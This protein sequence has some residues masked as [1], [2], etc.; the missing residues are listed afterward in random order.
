[1][2]QKLQKNYIIL[3]L[4]LLLISLS[5][6][7]SQNLNVFDYDY[8][9][10]PVNLKINN[11]ENPKYIDIKLLSNSPSKYTKISICENNSESNNYIIS[12]FSDEK[13]TKSIQEDKIVSGNQK[14]WL[15][16]FQA[17]EKIYLNVECDILP[18][19][20]ILNISPE[21]NI[22]L[23]NSEQINYYVNKQNLEMT[24]IFDLKSVGK[25]EHMNIWADGEFEIITKLS[26][27]NN[28]IENMNNNFYSFKPANYDGNELTLKVTAKKGD[29]VNVG[30]QIYEKN[31]SKNYVTIDDIPVLSFLSENE[32]E[33]LQKLGVNTDYTNN[34]TNLKI[35]SMELDY[36]IENT[37]RFYYTEI[38][39]DTQGSITINFKRGSGK[40]YA[41]II[42]TNETTP[43]IYDFSNITD[44]S[45]DYLFYYNSFL[46]KINFYNYYYENDNHL[47]LLMVV[48][49]D[50]KN[51]KNLFRSFPF[52]IIL[53][54]TTAQRTPINISPDEYIIGNLRDASI[55]LMTEL[56]YMQIKND[57]D[58]IIIDFQSDGAYLFININNTNK[59]M[60]F[61][62]PDFT[63]IPSGK[64]SVYTITKS[65]IINTAKINKYDIYIDDNNFADFNLIIGLF[66]NVSDT[67]Y[68]TVFS[69]SVHLKK[70]ENDLDIYK[71]NSDQK[72]L[73]KTTFISNDEDYPYR[74]LYIISPENYSNLT[75]L[76][77][78]ANPQ[79]ESI[80]YQIYADYLEIKD[81]NEKISA[82]NI[83]NKNSKFSTD[84]TKLDY[85]YLNEGLN[86]KY[87][88]VS[89][90]SKANTTI[91]LM[92]SFNSIEEIITPNPSTP[93]LFIINNEK[94]ELIFN[95]DGDE[96]AINLRSFSGDAEIYWSHKTDNKFYLRGRD[97]RLLIFASEESNKLIIKNLNAVNNNTKNEIP[98]LA[99]YLEYTL[100][101]M[102][103]FD[104][105]QFGKSVNFEYINPNFPIEIYTKL[106]NYEK[107]INIFFSFYNIETENNEEVSDKITVKAS[108]VKQVTIYNVKGNPETSIGTNMIPG[109]YDPGLRAGFFRLTKDN[110]KNFEINITDLPNLYIS[111]TDNKDGKISYN[112]V[113]LEMTVIQENSLIL[114][115][116]KIYQYGSLN[117]NEINVYKLRPNLNKP[118]MRI[119]FSSTGNNIKYYI[120]KS[121]EYKNDDNI[122]IVNETSCNG[123]ELIDIYAD[124]E[125]NDYLYLHLYR[126]NN[127]SDQKENFAFKYIN[128]VQ[129]SNLKVYYIE[130]S[131]INSSQTDGNLVLEFYPVP[132]STLFN[133]TYLVKLIKDKIITL[134]ETIAV[135]SNDICYVKEFKNPNI[136][137][138][139]INLK[140]PNNQK[141]IYYVIIY[142]LVNDK[143]IKE[144]ISYK[145]LQLNNNKNESS[146]STFLIVMVIIILLVTVCV[147]MIVFL[148]VFF[149]RNK[150]L[151]YKV[152]KLSFKTDE[153]SRDL[154]GT[155]LYKNV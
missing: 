20:Y 36:I 146:S 18:C 97:D 131:K 119:E 115:T 2:K 155:A 67:V 90:V 130:D 133:V 80:Q 8:E 148:F 73:C 53:R 58:K 33:P 82:S 103:N 68:T 59:G 144:Y 109:I 117:S 92:S 6:I 107:D 137:N 98:S 19:N 106:P 147:I 121:P 63:F 44:D 52:S 14:L 37:T 43:N 116:E 3:Y 142:A 50:T 89:V 54:S 124:P 61:L 114:A 47:F 123:R 132:N 78:Y 138:E 125:K 143:S 145:V 105:I 91:E 32:N 4:I 126:E 118:N 100:K 154:G 99:F 17:N 74:C 27:E 1:M 84:K 86:N 108:V 96:L 62:N 56:Y 11:S 15:S 48:V 29:F 30:S 134:K 101:A 122:T 153:E 128:Y 23:N 55:L 9:N 65:E 72:T 113:S 76:L 13:R 129:S 140:I 136:T 12:V 10:K 85:I 120:T 38:N 152:N 45:Y 110:F 66:A 7:I 88:F 40:V 81:Y 95:A 64:D 141:D 83:P 5:S 151:M 24:F 69:F 26:I 112:K 149:K 94:L 135:S 39:Y 21:E 127:D 41:K 60:Y 49:T 35:N 51:S 25:N 150:D 93:Q 31:L 46:K 87:L 16:E 102:K 57:T 71:V 75:E 34:I 79:N 77:V 139:K 22:K 111:I 70:N 104:E 28:V 42:S